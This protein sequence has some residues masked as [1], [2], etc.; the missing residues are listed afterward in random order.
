MGITSYQWEG[1]DIDSLQVLFYDK[2]SFSGHPCYYKD[3]NYVYGM[4]RELFFPF[5]SGFD[6]ETLEVM[7]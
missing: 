3:K 5:F 1:I 4:N 7:A 2:Y 6:Y